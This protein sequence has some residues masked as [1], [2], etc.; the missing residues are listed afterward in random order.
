MPESLRRSTDNPAAENSLAKRLDLFRLERDLSYT[1]LS[2]LIGGISF[3]TARRACM[4]AS[5]TSRTIYKIERFLNSV[6]G[7]NHAA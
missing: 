4:G 3:E 6:Q 1:Q 5:L 2:Q 7:N